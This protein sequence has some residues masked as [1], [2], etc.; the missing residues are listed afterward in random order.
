MAVR[1]VKKGESM[2]PYYY[3]MPASQHDAGELVLLINLLKEHGTRVYR[4]ESEL[5][6]GNKVVERGSIVVPLAQ[7]F[8]A[9]IKEV[10]EVQEFPER[11]YTPGGEMIN[12]YDITSWSLPLHKGVNV[13][14]INENEN[15][16][17]NAFSKLEIPYSLYQASESEFNSILLSAKNNNSYKAVFTAMKNGLKVEQILESYTFKNKMFPAGSFI[18]HKSKDA[19]QILELLNFTPEYL[20]ENITVNKREL[21][22]PRIAL[23]ETYFHAMD[24]GWTRFVLDSYNI[25]FKTI[26]PEEVQGIDFSKDY[27]VLIIPD[28]KKSVLIKGTYQSENEHYYIKYPPEYMKGMEDNGYEKILKFIND[29]GKAIAW[30]NATELFSGIQKY[31]L[32]D[33]N[34]EEF[35]F[36]VKDVSSNIVKQGFSCPGSLLRINLKKNHPITYGMPSEVG[37]F[38]RSGPVFKTWQPYFDVDRRV[39]GT[40]PERNILLSGYAENE[41]KIGNMTSIV[42]LKKGKGQVVLF[43]FNPQFRAS[44]P[45]TYK[46]LFNS[47]LL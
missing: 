37:V 40:F 16:F 7:P 23:L 42:W 13:F 10:M 3:I 46:L 18:I 15:Y 1:E 12:P 8:R 25:P 47:I 22:L 30:R 21:K 14:E 26:R 17:K 35:E 34:K 44:T 45:A 43:S 36:P 33:K 2:A 5:V 38:H 39:I 19:N 28:E 31:S 27:D 32:D 4:A 20:S 29:G 6:L 11:H 24:A 41:E 9:F